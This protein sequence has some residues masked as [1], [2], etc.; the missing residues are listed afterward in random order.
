ME[1]SDFYDQRGEHA[2]QKKS[3]GFGSSSI[4][5]KFRAPYSYFERIL[6]LPEVGA[7]FL[8]IG[9]GTGVHS[10]HPAR[11]GYHVTGI[12][13]SKKSIEAA[14]ALNENRCRF[15]ITNALDFLKSTPNQ[16]E[17]I[18]TSGSLYY[19]DINE[20]I[21]LIKSKLKPGGHFFCIETNGS[22]KILN[23]V[24]KLRGDRDARTVHHLL[25]LNDLKYLQSEFKNSTVKHFALYNMPIVPS[26]SFK[27]VFHGQKE[28]K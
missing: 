2:L 10:V 24:R 19:F 6:P 13:L 1:T 7:G 27:F 4:P 17:V 9:C 21:P 8:D 11:M 16:F 25:G 3:R 15:E 28:A 20:I 14:K 23:Q 22:N 18:F 26:L 12:D 5:E